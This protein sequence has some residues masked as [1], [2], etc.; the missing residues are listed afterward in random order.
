LETDSQFGVTKALI[1]D[2]QRRA[3]GTYFLQFTFV[4]EPG[5]ARLPRAPITEKAK[6]LSQ[7]A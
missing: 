4:I 2:Y 6:A 5:E 7:R 1:G 3:D